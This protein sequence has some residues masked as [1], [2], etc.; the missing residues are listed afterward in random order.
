MFRAYVNAS[1][2]TLKKYVGSKKQKKIKLYHSTETN[3]NKI[4]K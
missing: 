4:L 2:K 3:R 1:L